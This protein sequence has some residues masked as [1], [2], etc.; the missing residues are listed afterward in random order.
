M[1]RTDGAFFA[2]GIVTFT[3]ANVSLGEHLIVLPVVD[4]A[5]NQGMD[6]V[7]IT[8]VAD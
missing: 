7:G 6:S 8:M 5:G 3:Y 1:D 2:E 4:T